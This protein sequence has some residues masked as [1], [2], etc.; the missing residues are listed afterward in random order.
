MYFF[1]PDQLCGM[2]RGFIVLSVFLRQMFSCYATNGKMA[3]LLKS[4][5][6]HLTH[7]FLLWMVCYTNWINIKISYIRMSYGVNQSHTKMSFGVTLGK[8]HKKVSCRI[9]LSHTKQYSVIW[10]HTYRVIQSSK[11]RPTEQLTDQSTTDGRKRVW[12]LRPTDGWTDPLIEM[13][14]RIYNDGS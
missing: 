6:W 7:L 10:G 12:T 2:F 8:S 13:Q 3:S 4:R 11:S 14:G 5:N 9:T 1:L